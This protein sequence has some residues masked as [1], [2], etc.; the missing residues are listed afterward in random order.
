VLNGS[1]SGF[2][3]SIVV[4]GAAM[5]VSGTAICDSNPNM[6]VDF[7]GDFVALGFGLEAMGQHGVNLNGHITNAPM[8]GD[9]QGIMSGTLSQLGVGHGAAG[10]SGVSLV[11]WIGGNMFGQGRRAI[12][13]LETLGVRVGQGGVG[14]GIYSIWGPMWALQQ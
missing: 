7:A 5:G 3:G 9:M 1:I 11:F 12:F 13:A 10:A 8:I 14:G 2:A 4:G 6:R